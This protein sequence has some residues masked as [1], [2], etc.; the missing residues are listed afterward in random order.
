MVCSLQL[1]GVGTCRRATRIIAPPGSSD[2]Q[3]DNWLNTVHGG[4]QFPLSTMPGEQVD[5]VFAGQMGPETIHFLECC[6]LDRPVMVTPESARMV[7]ETYTAADLSAEYTAPIDLP[8][9]NQ[10]LAAVQDMYSKLKA[11]QMPDTQ[12]H[13]LKSVLVFVSVYSRVP[14]SGGS[15]PGSKRDRS[16]V[17]PTPS[18]ISS[19]IAS[20]VAGALRM[21]QTPWPVAT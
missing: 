15:R 9:S 14:S 19:V 10:N 20:P 2:T 4:T 7:M 3:H 6:I 5:H 12:A 16:S 8:L 21:P 13:R 11:E 17:R 1:A 18:M